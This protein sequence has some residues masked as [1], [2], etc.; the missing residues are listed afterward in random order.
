VPAGIELAGGVREH[1]ADVER[2]PAEQQPHRVDELPGGQHRV[3]HRGGRAGDARKQRGRVQRTGG[4]AHDQV[5]AAGHAQPLQGGR[6]PG[7]DD[8]THPAALEHHR[9]PVVIAAGT[10]RGAALHPRMQDVENGVRHRGRHR[11]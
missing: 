2:R 3:V 8:A 7:G 1:E 6:H 5:E 11:C 10:G 9:D 4:G